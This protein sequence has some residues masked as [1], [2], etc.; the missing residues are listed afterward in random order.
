M[1]LGRVL[2]LAAGPAFARPTCWKI[3]L[4]SLA[5]QFGHITIQQYFH[6]AQQL[7]DC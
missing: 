5:S 6:M 3:I 4:R 2:A 1:M 7:R